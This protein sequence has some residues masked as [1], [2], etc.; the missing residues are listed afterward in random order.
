M[1][2]RELRDVFGAFATG[3]TVVTTVDGQGAYQGVTANSFSSLSLDPP[4]VLW[5]Q[6]LGARSFPA[7]RDARHFLVNILAADQLEVSRRFAA[8]GPDKFAGLTVQRVQT[9]LPALPG[10]CA[11][12][13]CRKVGMHP[14]GDHMIHI[15]EVLSF[16]HHPRPPLVF[17]RGRYGVAAEHPDLSPA[18]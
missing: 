8:S 12:L 17:F 14:G 1:G 10:C 18:A 16:A 9:G 15:G 13:E 7:F 5:S 3:V 6:A 11:W 2:E 4:L